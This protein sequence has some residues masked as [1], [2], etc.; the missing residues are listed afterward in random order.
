MP[1]KKQRAKKAKQTKAAACHPAEQQDAPL[2]AAQA[3]RRMHRRAVRLSRSGDPA[4]LPSL[5]DK[6]YL[7]HNWNDDLTEMGSAIAQGMCKGRMGL[8]T[9]HDAPLTLLLQR[10]RMQAGVAIGRFDC[11]YRV[12]LFG[13]AWLHLL[14]GG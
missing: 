12:N 14:S 6:T 13:P 3:M 9:G 10:E 7:K 2:T 1:S 8:A 11:A 4:V 5:L